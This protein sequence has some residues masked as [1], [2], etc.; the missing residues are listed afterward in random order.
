MSFS[1][2]DAQTMSNIVAAAPVSATGRPCAG[3]GGGGSGDVPAVCEDLLVL[4]TSD[5]LS[6]FAGD[7]RLCTVVHSAEISAASASAMDEINAFRGD[8]SM[9]IDESFGSSAAGESRPAPVQLHGLRDA[10]A[11]RVTLDGSNESLHHKAYRVVLDYGILSP[12]VNACLMAFHSCDA[13]PRSLAFTL[14]IDTIRCSQLYGTS[15]NDVTANEWAAFCRIILTLADEVLANSGPQFPGFDPSSPTAPE[16]IKKKARRKPSVPGADGADSD[17]PSADDLLEIDEVQGDD[18]DWEFLV[19]SEYHQAH[20]FKRMLDR[21]GGGG[22]AQEAGGQPVDD[23]MA[24][25]PTG[26]GGGPNSL[27]VPV[28]EP[29]APETEPEPMPDD[30]GWLAGLG[31]SSAEFGDHIATIMQVT[32]LSARGGALASVAISNRGMLRAESPPVGGCLQVLHLVYEDLKLNVLTASEHCLRPLVTLLSMLARRLSLHNHADHYMR[33]FGDVNSSSAKQLSAEAARKL[34]VDSMAKDPV[35]NMYQWLHDCLQG[36]SPPRSLVVGQSTDG[37]DHARP[38]ALG[39][40]LCSQTRKIC[41]LYSLMEEGEC[42]RTFR[43]LSQTNSKVKSKLPR[44]RRQ[45][46]VSAVLFES[47][48]AGSRANVSIDQRDDRAYDRVLPS[49][50]AAASRYTIY[51]AAP[52]HQKVVL[53]MVTAGI[54]PAELE[55]LPIGMALPLRESI[56]SCRH[57]PP[58]DWPAAAYVLIGRE[59]L[60]WTVCERNE[61]ELHLSTTSIGSIGWSKSAHQKSS[62]PNAETDIPLPTHTASA[63]TGDGGSATAA[64][65]ANK[66]ANFDGTELGTNLPFMRFGRDER[67]KEVQRILR[68]S[69]PGPLRLVRAPE[70]SDHEYIEQQQKKLQSLAQRTMA[71]SV[72]RGMFTLYTSRPTVTDP[73]PI[74]ELN[75]SGR[76][77]PNDAIVSLDQSGLPADLE[78][79]PSFHNGVAAGLRLPPGQ[80][81][82]TRTWIVYNK[83]DSLTDEHAGV[84]MALGLTG[85]LSSLASADLVW[86][87]SQR[88][89]TTAVG[90]MLGMAA[91]RCGSMDNTISKM[92]C[93]HIL[94]FHPP[95]FPELDVSSNLQTAAIMGIGLL[96]QGTANRFMTEV[97]LGEIGRRAS[98]SIAVDRE[99]YSLAAGLALGFVTLGQGNKAVGLTVNRPEQF[100]LGPR[101]ESPTFS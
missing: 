41:Y 77:P 26:A 8:G 63:A 38:G 61:I 97:L 16:S 31:T 32:L 18:R 84:L 67:L 2:A 22:G 14:R 89:E 75:L 95:T 4:D 86:Y 9:L 82:A 24:T 35:P 55:C 70:T 43:I 45:R 87:L 60:A 13:I 27:P 33:D 64:A 15:M 79:W 50:R 37:G 56:W 29:A 46:S 101:F 99:G 36:R 81:H 17:E 78:K 3:D 54:T 52:V 100:R 6:L 83:P 71:I 20:P 88:H 73:L 28:A 7:R 39:D 80:S 93:M 92:L 12:A 96:Y 69:R 57:N 25:S 10:V 49:D 47:A 5:T 66:P 44:S 51:S 72:G 68:S 74:P 65:A 91:A 62:Q 76:L 23:A 19:S 40:E 48:H 21:L 1:L 34:A 90:V 58:L 94:A 30:A 98:D 42:S 59:D 11:N 53:G 85:H